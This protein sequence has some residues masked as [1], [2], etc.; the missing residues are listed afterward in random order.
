MCAFAFARGVCA[1]DAASG[2]VATGALG[3]MVPSD[4]FGRRVDEIGTRM[5]EHGGRLLKTS[6]VDV[7]ERILARRYVKFKMWCTCDMDARGMVKNWKFL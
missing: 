5:A 2:S 4:S 1:S 7:M 3:E 6:S